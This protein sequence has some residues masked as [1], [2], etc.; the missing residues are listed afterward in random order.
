MSINMYINID[1]TSVSLK[2]IIHEDVRLILDDLE[3]NRQALTDTDYTRT[4]ETITALG[5][6]ATNIDIIARIG[7]ES[8]R[9]DAIRQLTRLTP[10]AG[11]SQ[12]RNVEEVVQ[13]L[14][15]KV[16]SLFQI[17]KIESKN[18]N[19]EKFFYEAF[20]SHPCFNGRV[21]AIQNYSAEN[22]FKIPKSALDNY[23]VPSEVTCE[24]LVLLYEMM[25]E[26]PKMK[27]TMEN[28]KN[29]LEKLPN[30]A[31]SYQATV[32]SSSFEAIW[33][34]VKMAADPD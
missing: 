9:N 20:Q 10:E 33:I 34:Y 22:I 1:N 26:N 24:Y 15:N 5:L 11:F 6:L 12:G 21:E 8:D 19:L 14:S 4:K 3:C 7:K 17:Y 31:A 27:L 2:N 32:E 16:E 18:D 28:F 29:Y 30:Y 23:I 13:V 25:E